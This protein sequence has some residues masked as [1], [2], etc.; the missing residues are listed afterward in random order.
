MGIY[1]NYFNGNDCWDEL[2]TSKAERAKLRK[3]WDIESPHFGGSAGHRYQETD[4]FGQ[5]RCVYCW[6]PEGYK[7]LKAVA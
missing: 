3:Q 6:K 2:H 4:K 7:S 1:R 5:V